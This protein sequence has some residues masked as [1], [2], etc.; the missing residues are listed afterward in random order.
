MVRGLR[1]SDQT[2][3]YSVLRAIGRHVRGFYPAVGVF[4]AI[5]LAL[6]AVSLVLFAGLARW[7]SGSTVPEVDQA[8]L[9][10]IRRHQAPW[11]DALALLGA[12]LGSGAAMWTLLLSGTAFLWYSRHHYSTVLLWISLLGGRLLNRVLKESFDRPR[13]RLVDGDLSLLGWQIGFPRSASFP[14][15][16]AMGAMVMYGT[17]AYLIVRL[18]PTR[19]MRRFTLAMAALLVLGIG[20]SRVYLAVHYPSDVLA[21]YLAGFIWATSCVLAIE[22][23][24]YFGDRNPGVRAAEADL[25]RGIQPIREALHREREP[26]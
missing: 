9:L 22:A 19:R 4:L 18:E 24:R 21:G 7:I 3:I 2:M 20:L 26:Y 25:D 5:G 6:S 13:P 10:W 14:S 23:V 15:G 8:V 16:H 1:C 17:L 12:G 11:L